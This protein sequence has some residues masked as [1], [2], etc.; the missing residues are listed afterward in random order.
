MVFLG[1]SFKKPAKQEGAGWFGPSPAFEAFPPFWLK[2]QK[3]AAVAQWLLC[4]FQTLSPQN[5]RAVATIKGRSTGDPGGLHLLRSNETK[6]RPWMDPP[7]E[8]SEN[9][10]PLD[11]TTKSGT[12]LEMVPFRCPLNIMKREN[13][14]FQN[15]QE[16]KKKHKHRFGQYFRFWTLDKQLLGGGIDR[17]KPNLGFPKTWKA[18]KYSAPL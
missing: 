1:F 6:T 14:C 18:W 12:P 16:E 9:G 8:I 11:Q 17:F 10:E 15:P 4:F 13:L 5:R 3:Q 2:G 7:P